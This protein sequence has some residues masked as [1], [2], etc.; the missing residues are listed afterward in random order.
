ML[1]TVFIDI[2]FVINKHSY[3]VQQLFSFVT[4]MARS[5][6]NILGDKAI[7][8]LNDFDV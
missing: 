2:F 5:E 3:E 4:N 6:K 8:F 1:S 7:I